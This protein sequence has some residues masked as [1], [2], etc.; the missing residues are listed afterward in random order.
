MAIYFLPGICATRVLTMTCIVVYDG[1]DFL[2]RVGDDLDELVQALF[3]CEFYIETVSVDKNLV[4][5]AVCVFGIFTLNIVLKK[6]VSRAVSNWNNA[7]V[8]KTLVLVA[9]RVQ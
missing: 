6:K 3:V 7:L 8:L 1:E 5:Q 4:S 2:V 9:H